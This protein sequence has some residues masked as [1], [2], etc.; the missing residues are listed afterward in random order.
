MDSDDDTEEAVGKFK[1]K[2]LNN[3]NKRAKNKAK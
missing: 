1:R 3:S 2:K